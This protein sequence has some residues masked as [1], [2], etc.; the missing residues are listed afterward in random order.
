MLLEQRYPRREGRGF[1]VDKAAPSPL[2][3]QEDPTPTFTPAIAHPPDPEPCGVSPHLGQ[4]AGTL[5]RAKQQPLTRPITRRRQRCEIRQPLR[6]LPG[7]LCDHH[8][9]VV[10]K[11][12]PS[13]CAPSAPLGVLLTRHLTGCLLPLRSQPRR[14]SGPHALPPPGVLLAHRFFSGFGIAPLLPSPKY[15]GRAGLIPMLGSPVGLGVPIV[16]FI[17]HVSPRGC[18]ASPG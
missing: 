9:G 14:L 6:P 12:T 4:F 18:S 2:D 8:P 17:P 1:P 10:P 16:H 15:W 7:M 11:G 5:R 3:N 13:F